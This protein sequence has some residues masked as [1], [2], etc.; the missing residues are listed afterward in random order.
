MGHTS[1]IGAHM[2]YLT[3][4]TCFVPCTLYLKYIP[5]HSLQKTAVKN[6]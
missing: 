6:Q 5:L 1:Q 4:M 2:T 3:F